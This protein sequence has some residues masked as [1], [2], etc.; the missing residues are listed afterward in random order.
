MIAISKI[1]GATL[2]Q[3]PFDWSNNVSNIKEAI[4][5][6]KEKG[7][8]LLCMPELSLTGYGCEDFFLSDWLPKK[9][10][11]I[12]INEIVPA[13][14]DIIVN[15]GLPVLFQDRLYNCAC[16]IQ[17]G[18]ILGF[19][20]KQFL[21]NDGVHYEHRWFYPWPSTEIEVIEIEG[22]R[23]PFGDYIF[24]IND[25]KIAF[26]ICEDAWRPN[27]PAILHY[28]NKVDIILNPSASPFEVR[29]SQRR[30]DLVISSSREFDCTYVYCNLL[31]NESGKLIFDGEVLIA[32]KGNWVAGN[33]RLSFENF[34][35]V[36]STSNT[37]PKIADVN[38][39]FAQA[40]SLGLFDYLRKSNTKAFVLSLSGGADSS[41]CAVLVSEMV[42]RG[43]LELGREAFLRKA[44]LPDYSEEELRSKILICAYQ[45]TVNSSQSTFDSAQALAEELGATFYNWK[46]DEE[47]NSYRNKI[48]KVLKRE[49]DWKNNDIALQNI[50]ARARSPI[51]WLL[52]NLSGALLLT[53]SNRSEGD[54]GYATMDGDTSGSLAPIAGID[55]AFIRDWLKWAEKELGY[56]S[57]HHV[58][59]LAPS[60]ELRPL[61]M[62]QSDEDDLMPYD[63]LLKIEHFA[64]KDKLPPT[65]TY[66]ALIK[67][68]D[69]APELVKTYIKKFYRLWSYNQ[70]KRERTAPS[71]HLDSFNVDP[72][73]WM[74]FPILSG[75]FQ[76]ELKELDQLS[77]D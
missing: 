48:E 6:A 58:N 68:L 62:T 51:I 24:K 34:N 29:K 12:L 30:Q 15:I 36:T 21:A 40:V 57:L 35:I 33:Q 37:Q 60:A 42:K 67:E 63:I 18:N 23:Y 52:T 11:E 17:D 69:I 8:E 31:G 47:V 20:A 25:T 55:K 45:G 19:T 59:N 14:D 26:E 77:Y 7:I 61:D 75:S 4:I 72:K 65:E 13:T 53:T 16:L 44:G 2:N 71:F 66:R 54:V 1:A 3:I 76:R 5:A 50:Q 70:W 64:I 27:R 49:L 41:T 43:T 22:Q 74:R 32:D 10:M 46:I 56:L 28:E 39:E 38:D 9:A 73:S